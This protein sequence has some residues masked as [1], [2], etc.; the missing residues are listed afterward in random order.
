MGCGADLR[1]ETHGRLKCAKTAALQRQSEP[2]VKV[3]TASQSLGIQRLL[4]EGS[5]SSTVTLHRD[6]T[7]IELSVFT[8]RL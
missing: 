8:I 4:R 1:L 3:D 5:L 2:R 7:Q 6:P